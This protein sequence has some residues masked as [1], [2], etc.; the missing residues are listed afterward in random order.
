MSLLLCTGAR[1]G[2]LTVP[3]AADSNLALEQTL[4][5]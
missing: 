1:G 2:D 4:Q 3:G 5:L